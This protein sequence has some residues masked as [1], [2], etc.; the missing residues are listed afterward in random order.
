MNNLINGL[1]TT[2]SSKSLF[3]G[4]YFG[5]SVLVKRNIIVNYFLGKQMETSTAGQLSYWSLD[6]SLN[7]Y[8]SNFGAALLA[9]GKIIV[10]G[11]L[12]T[13]ST[14]TSAC[15]FYLSSTGWV[16]T[17]EMKTARYYHTHTLFENNTKVLAAGNAQSSS[18]E[19][20]EVFDSSTITWT[21]THRR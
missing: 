5:A 16:S 17:S 2:A 18:A 21:N 12:L 9:N 3:Y 8:R 4:E 15:E 14:P 20:A 10:N 7:T 1:T 6:A 11:G 13:S 19:T